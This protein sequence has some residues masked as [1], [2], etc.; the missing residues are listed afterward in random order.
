MRNV[1]ITFQA[2]S[3]L[4]SERLINSFQALI[5]DSTGRCFN[6]AD[7]IQ[8]ENE[9]NLPSIPTVTLYSQNGFI[10]KIVGL[11]PGYSGDKIIKLLSFCEFKME[12]ATIYN[13]LNRK[14]INIT[15][16]NRKYM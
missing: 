4:T 9:V 12:D 15:I 10:I 14:E 16:W 13:I 3:Y 1:T 5:V 6:R 11:H 2:G 7:I 8:K